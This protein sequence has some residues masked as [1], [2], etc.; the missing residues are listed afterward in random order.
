MRGRN[1]GSYKIWLLRRLLHKS[2]DATGMVK[3][4]VLE[5]YQSCQWLIT[6][7]AYLPCRGSM[8][9]LLNFMD[10]R[11]IKVLADRRRTECK[12]SNACLYVFPVESASLNVFTSKVSSSAEPIAFAGGGIM[13]L[14]IMLPIANGAIIMPMGFIPLMPFIAE[15][16]EPG[17]IAAGTPFAQ[18]EWPPPVDRLDG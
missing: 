7:F 14:G 18:A 9:I 17:A 12:E 2:V 15:F 13:K 3:I 11:N 10:I 4:V 6:V 8:A 16:C 5:G 1:G